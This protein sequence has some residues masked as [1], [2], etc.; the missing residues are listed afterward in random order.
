MDI[1]GRSLSAAAVIAVIIFLRRVMFKKM[2]KRVLSALWLIAAAKLLIPSGAGAAAAAVSHVSDAVAETSYSAVPA[3]GAPSGFSEA[4]I[5]IAV[6]VPESGLPVPLFRYIWLFGA[7]FTA[8]I[9]VM[10]HIKSRRVFS[11][12]VPADYDIE[13]LKSGFGIIRRVRLLVSD[14]A[15]SPLTYG[16]FAPVI[17]LPKGMDIRGSDMRNVLCHELAHIKRLDALFKTLLAACAAAYWFNP[18]VWIMFVLANRDIELAC[19]ETALRCGRTAPEEYAMTLIT[20]EEGR[21]F[22]RGKSFYPA[23]SFSGGSL[24]ERIR[25]V[26]TKRKS[27]LAGISAASVSVLAAA[28]LNIAVMPYGAF[29]GM[30]V[31]DADARTVEEYVSYA[32]VS[33][34]PYIYAEEAS[35]AAYD[36]PRVL[37][38]PVEITSVLCGEYDISAAE[39]SEV[40]V[41]AVPYSDYSAEDSEIGRTAE[42]G[43]PAVSRQPPPQG[44]YTVVHDYP[45]MAYAYTTT[46]QGGINSDT[47]VRI[48]ISEN[49]SVVSWQTSVTP[50][51]SR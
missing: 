10:S 23:G 19:D 7:V 21:R 36:D 30:A 42:A 47:T 6:P 48:K 37:A 43:G 18:F 29:Y 35:E 14:R 28:V 45:L 32:V 20:V 5:R 38:L 3:Y 17:I 50:I 8:S 25:D 4:V 49:G 16:V 15:D 11:C 13:P 34:S 40:T 27:A 22:P 1:I 9:F 31:S 12:A 24:E 26:M 51:S 2:P 46:G 41:E 33:D 39:Y 44:Y